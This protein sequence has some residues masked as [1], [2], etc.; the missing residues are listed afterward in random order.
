MSQRS[1]QDILLNATRPQRNVCGADLAVFTGTDTENVS[2]LSGTPGNDFPVATPARLLRGW[3]VASDAKTDDD[4]ALL[5]GLS[6]YVNRRI[7]Q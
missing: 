2:V 1:G 7:H 5:V 3:L 6:D 4:A